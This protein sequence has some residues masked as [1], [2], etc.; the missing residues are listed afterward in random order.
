MLH[1]KILNE[2]WFLFIFAIVILHCYLIDIRNP[3]SPLNPP[4]CFVFTPDVSAT[5]EIFYSRTCDVPQC[6]G[7]VM[8]L[9]LSPDNVKFVVQQDNYPLLSYY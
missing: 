2:I 1:Y 6:Q 3:Y 8:Y 5:G 7:R 4:W 9:H